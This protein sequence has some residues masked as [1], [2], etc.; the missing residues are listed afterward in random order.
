MT[1][2]PMA[3]DLVPILRAER[4][5][6]TRDELDLYDWQLRRAM[7]DDLRATH[8]KNGVPELQAVGEGAWVHSAPGVIVHAV[9]LLGACAAWTW[10]VLP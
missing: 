3:A 9:L 2:A 8:G 10:V 5:P 4:E 1:S 7:R 6:L